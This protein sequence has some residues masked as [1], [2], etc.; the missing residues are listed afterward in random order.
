[1]TGRVRLAGVAVPLF[2]LR[3]EADSGIGEIFDLVPFSDWAASAGQRMIALLPLGEVGTGEASP[4]NALSSFAIDPLYLTLS[5]VPELAGCRDLEPVREPVDG[6]ARQNVDHESVRVR[7]MPWLREAFARFHALPDGDARVRG[8]RAFRREQESWLEDYSL[9]RALSEAHGECPWK[10]WPS[11]LRER[12]SH[13]LDLA[14][15]RLHDRIEFFAYLQFVAEEQW[16]R[17]REHA[18]RAGV[19]L[20][21]DLPFAPAENSADVWAN[22][23]I[24][25]LSRSIGAPPDAFSETGQRWGLPMYRWEGLRQRH[26][27]WFRSRIRRMAD[28]YDFYRIDHVVGLFR[29]FWFAGESAG[30]FEPVEVPAQQ[31]QG[32]EILEIIR[33]ESGAAVPVAE[34]LGVIPD[35]VRRC[36][37]E[38]E[39]PG[40][41][42]L[43]WERTDGGFLDPREYPD[44]SIATTGTHDTEPLVAWWAAL[45]EADRAQVVSLLG[46]SGSPPR[47]L[48]PALR[49]DLLGRLYES[50]SRYVV[51][52]IQDFFGWNERINRPATIGPEN[53]SFRL[54]V[55]L[56]D[57]T[58]T[59]GLIEESR[60]LR[61]RIDAA[62]RLERTF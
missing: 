33:A 13:A 21:G 41:K 46:K 20:M 19:A 48:V 11:R 47:H 16:W 37:A 58:S 45:P 6:D 24:F 52:P 28:L 26:W 62:G 2:S 55:K 54:P 12:D 15:A 27:R 53:W 35:F 42:V 39:I 4:Y 3:S 29:T 36:L 25:D 56:A 49:R 34:D 10:D 7:K 57:L 38:L 30:G 23:Q 31:A 1:M 40:Y 50:G 51:I 32:R 8:F 17:A 59:P 14:R 44:C 9:F 5:E 22:Q 61:E 18:R 43:R 60:L